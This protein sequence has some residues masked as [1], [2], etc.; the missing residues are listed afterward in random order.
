MKKFT[1]LKD[2]IQSME[3]D[4]TKFAEKGNAAAGARI[5]ATLQ[6]IKKLSQEF[7]IEIQEIKKSKKPE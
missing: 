5:R 1:D 2:K 7:R 3:E 4:V 6:E